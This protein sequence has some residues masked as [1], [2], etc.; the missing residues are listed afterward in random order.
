MKGKENLSSRRE[1]REIKAVRE[2]TFNRFG[3]E[4]P[5]FKHVPTPTMISYAKQMG[6][7]GK[8]NNK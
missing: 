2:W 1:A 8:T 7:V 3:V 4:E 6:V 5:D